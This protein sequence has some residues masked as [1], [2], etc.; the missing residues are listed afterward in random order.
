MRTRHGSIVPVCAAIGVVFSVAGFAWAGGHTWKLNEIFSDSTGTIQFIELR[1]SLGG[2]NE[3]AVAGHQVFTATPPTHSYTIPGP[4]VTPPTGFKTLLFA[5]PAAAALPGFPTP[6]YILPAAPFF[7]TVNDTVTATGWGSF[8]YAA[9][10]LPT[11]GVHSLGPLGVIACMTPRNYAGATATLN[12]GC[13]MLGDVNGD[14][15]VDGGDVGGFVRSSIGV[16][17]FG[18][19]AACAE[20]CLGSVAANTAAFVNDLLN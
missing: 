16:P 14:G 10:G 1:E 6:N 5:T 13:T 9:G 12:L 4:N 7:S 2:P 17:V 3:V 19:N 11:D 8:V 20:Y 18:D 15:F